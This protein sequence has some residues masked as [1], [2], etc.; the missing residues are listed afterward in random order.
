MDVRQLRCFIAVAEE[1]HFS[2]A[3]QRLHVA[4]PAVSQTVKG[5]ERELGISLLDRSNRRVTLTEAGSVLLVEAYAIVHRVEGATTVMRRLRDADALR[6]T[7]GA[8]PALPPRL[9][10]AL[11]AR[12]RDELPELAVSMR[13]LP[14]DARL[15]DVLDSAGGVSLALLRKAKRT[16]GIVTRLLA[17]D[18]IGLALPAGHELSTLSAVPPAE[19]SGLPVV[20]FPPEADPE[21]HRKL[22]GTLTALGFTGPGA[23]YESASGAVDASLRLVANGTAVS[24]KLAS[25]VEA[26]DDPTVVWR[27]IAGLNITVFTYAAWRREAVH[28][29]LSRVLPLLPRPERSPV[30]S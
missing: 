13:T 27:P 4:Q 6:L 2:R 25:E 14:G 28:G 21:M 12:V 19:L 5:L 17:R 3:A 11:L 24:F 8:V 18:P 26:F 7:I 16:T 22:F 30:P 15:P 29:P 9:L 23:L 1:L 20:T 10:P